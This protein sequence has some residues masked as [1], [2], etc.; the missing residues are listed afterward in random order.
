MKLPDLNLTPDI[1]RCTR[2]IVKIV[3][4]LEDRPPDEGAFHLRKAN[5]IR[6]IHSSVAI[7]ANTLS[8]EE[9][10]DVINGKQIKG[11]PREIL[12]VKNAWNAYERIGEYR[13]YSIDDF[14]LAH[15]RMS[16]GLVSET[17]RF[18]S[19]RVGV[20]KGF[21]LIHE[22]AK[23]EEVEDLMEK[24]FEW[25]RM[26]NMHPLVKSCAI[27]FY[28]EN[29]H[30]FEDGNGRMG[31]LWQTVVLSDWHPLF[32]WLPVEALV[33]R[34][35]QA[36]YN[37]IRASEEKNDAA[38]F[39]KFMMDVIEFSLNALTDVASAVDEPAKH[40]AR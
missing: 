10:A 23:P 40:D 21:E 33:Y 31:R 5:R 7:E 3:K 39:V 11:N 17:G 20:Y 34:N 19:V 37:A 15:S 4:S 13:P 38:V 36:Y 26:S 25:G 6:S 2:R 29:V 28:I 35:Q 27:H 22:G 1:E 14:L 12:E 24:V 18:R 32:G 16:D 8:L 9:V 30:P